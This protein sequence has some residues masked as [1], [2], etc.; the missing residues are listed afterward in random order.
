MSGGSSGGGGNQYAGAMMAASAVTGM[1]SSFSQMSSYR[2]QLKIN[3]IQ[4]DLNEFLAEKAYKANM[5]Q[6]YEAQNEVKQQATQEMLEEQKEYRSRQAQLRVFQA[7]TGQEGQSAVDTHNQLTKSH[8]AWRQIQL[9]NIHKAERHIENQ[10]YSA[11]LSRAA[12][13]ASN[14]VAPASGNLALATLSGGLQ[15]FASGLSKYYKFMD[16]AE[17]DIGSPDYYTQDNYSYG[18]IDYDTNYGGDR[19]A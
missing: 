16:W 7:E 10:M 9:G 1:I 4:S 18:E 12:H 3:K 6:L 17:T 2:H 5:T 8:H 11:S 19:D 15:G 14:K 13:E